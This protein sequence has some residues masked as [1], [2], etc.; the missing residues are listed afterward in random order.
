[1]VQIVKHRSY[2]HLSAWLITILLAAMAS[3]ISCSTAQPSPPPRQIPPAAPQRADLLCKIELA[4]ILD[5][6]DFAELY[7]AI[8]AQNPDMPQTLD[9]ALNN[10][11]YKTGI[12]PRDF[13]RA[14]V[15]ADASTL[16]EIME[17]SQ[18][19]HG[20]PYYG[21]LVEESLD[22]SSLITNIE[23]K[24]GQDRGLQGTTIKV[25]QYIPL[26]PWIAK[27]KFSV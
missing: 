13:T 24:T 22:R 17:P 23:E 3:L 5:D 11:E 26:L 8:A 12:D 6:K 14:L 2:K 20:P 27:T 15:F 1:M 25:I 18:G 10:V 7:R 21:A 19:S 9:A 4:K 16:I